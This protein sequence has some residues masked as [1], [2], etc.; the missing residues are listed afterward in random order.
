MDTRVEMLLLSGVTRLCPDCGDERIFVPVYAATA[1]GPTPACDFDGCEFCCTS[2]G[3]ALL[4]DPAFDYSSR[5]S[6]RLRRS[7]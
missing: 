1:E 4:V 5:P 2:C 3:A 6:R 7:A